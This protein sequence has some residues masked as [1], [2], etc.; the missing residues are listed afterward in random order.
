MLTHSGFKRKF[1]HGVAVTLLLG[2]AGIAGSMISTGCGQIT[3]TP[4]DP[5]ATGKGVSML[6]IEPT[7]SSVAPGK[8][9][10]IAVMATDANGSPV[11]DATL[12]TLKSDDLGTISPT[13]ARTTFGI[14]YANFQAG[15]KTGVSTIQASTGG[16][17]QSISV[18]IDTNATPAP[19]P[20]A[21]KDAIDPGSI[22][23]LHSSP[24]DYRVTATLSDIRVYL[25]QTIAWQWTH[26]AWP[27][28]PTTPS[29]IGTM[30]V[31]GKVDGRWYGAGWEWLTENL[32]Q[33]TTEALPGE[34]PFIQT[35]AHPLNAWYPRAGEEV[36]FLVSTI[37]PSWSGVP[38]SPNERSPIVTIRWP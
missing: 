38:N 27:G 24:A 1:S 13:S 16:V 10:G 5:G 30:W 15:L 20:A 31:I 21:Y 7:A 23:W 37:T 25:P 22:T 9:L 18:R 12:I 28:T 11:K 32:S 2:A 33:A 34:P 8:T 36:G 19:A 29:V 3:T 4:I 35:K 6:R 26:P 14:V 17:A